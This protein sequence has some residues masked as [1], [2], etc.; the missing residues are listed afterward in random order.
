M[1]PVEVFVSGTPYD[2]GG[3]T[4]EKS[5]NVL[6]NMCYLMESIPSVIEDDNFQCMLDDMLKLYAVFH[7]NLNKIHCNKVLSLLIRFNIQGYLFLNDLVYD[8]KSSSFMKKVIEI[9]RDEKILLL[10]EDNNKIN[11]TKIAELLAQS[12]NS[13]SWV[14]R[15]TEDLEEVHYGEK[16]WEWFY[17][18]HCHDRSFYRTKVDSLILDVFNYFHS[19]EAESANCVR[20]EVLR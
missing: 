6:R 9:K 15:L 2:M 4:I 10:I 14:C 3:W 18:R 16:S 8:D 19:K 17:Q 7:G 1:N 5:E 11:R 20:I 13:D 12:N